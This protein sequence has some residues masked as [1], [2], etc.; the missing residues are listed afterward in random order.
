MAKTFLV[1]GGAGYIGS[2]AVK[3]LLEDGHT[4][5]VFDNFSRGYHEPLELLSKKG[6]LEIIEG[7]L[8][9][10]DDIAA[11]FKGRQFDGVFHFAALCLVD[12]SMKQPELYFQNNVVGSLN[13]L[14]GMRE[15]GTDTLVFSSTCATY[16]ESQYLP[17]DE[18]HPTNPTNPYGLSKRM[19]EQ[20]IEWYGRI[21]GLKYAVLRYFNVCG[22]DREG[23]IGDSKKPSQL[24][25]QNAVRGAMG[26][27]TFK[28]T[29]PE[30]NT[31]DGTPIRDYIDV[32]DLIEA[33]WLAYSHLQKGGDSCLCNIGSGTGYS[34]KQIVKEVESFFGIRMDMSRTTPRQGEYE[35]VY[36]D[37]TQARKLLGWSPEKSLR[38]S[39]ESLQKWYSGHPHGYNR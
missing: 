21:H 6:T 18:Q 30:V 24:L 25:M 26:I 39:I 22:C 12:E 14:E 2:H 5:I 28:L 15:A 10:P 29:C 16:G 20:M 23:T 32:E 9:N 13:L 7:D 33:H 4:V 35:K 3:K 27:E 34:V 11:L 31:T 36:A 38:D 8:R 17:M 19:V 1:T 37:T